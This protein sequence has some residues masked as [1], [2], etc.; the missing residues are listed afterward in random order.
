MMQ[1]SVGPPT[2]TTQPAS[3]LATVGMNITLNCL[4]TGTGLLTYNWEE[5]G[6]GNIWKTISDESSTLTIRN[7]QK[8]NQFRCTVSNEAGR[9]TSDPVDIT[10]LGK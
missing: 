3:Q 8:S 6:Q 10:M 4:G 1:I 9:T 7:I 5:R 2:I